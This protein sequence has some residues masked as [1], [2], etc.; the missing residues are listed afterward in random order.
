MQLDTKDLG[1]LHTL[2]GLRFIR[3][4]EY[5]ISGNYHVLKLLVRL[6]MHECRPISDPMNEGSITELD[7]NS[8]KLEKKF[9]E[10]LYY[11]YPQE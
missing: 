4:A 2:L 9:Q 1:S 3:E 10:H 7:F 6:E 5:C 11:V 8:I